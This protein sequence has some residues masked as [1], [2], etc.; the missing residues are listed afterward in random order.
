[1]AATVAGLARAGHVPSVIHG[2]EA[3]VAGESPGQF[4][5]VWAPQDTTRLVRDR[6]GEESQPD[7]QAAATLVGLGVPCVNGQST[8]ARATAKSVSAVLFRLAGLPHPNTRVL[9]DALEEFGPAP[10]VCKS[11][12][13]SQAHDVW[14]VSSLGEAREQARTVPNDTFI[15][16]ELIP[17]A[18]CVRVV[19]TPTRAIRAYEKRMP[20]GQAVAGV[21]I[22][23]ER[24]P[25]ADESGS[26]SA[27]ACRMVQACGLDIAGAD[28]LEDVDGRLWAL[29]LNAPYFGFDADDEVVVEALVETIERVAA[30]GF[31]AQADVA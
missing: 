4:D 30:R 13:G 12:R 27:L 2:P 14:I 21:T 5:V 8:T 26:V 23:G 22:G 16:Q 18:R 19:A 7:V 20:E 15:V 31:A 1:V 3:W 10:F 24:V 11:V 17:G 29:E 6:G 9:T 28:V 25:V